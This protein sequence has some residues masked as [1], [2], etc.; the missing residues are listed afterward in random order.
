MNNTSKKVI[1]MILDGW[2]IADVKESSAICKANTSFIDSLYKNYPNSQLGTSG[3]QVGL[4]DGQMGNSEVGHMNLGAGRI[5]YQDLVKINLAVED[6]S[7][8]NEKVLVEAFEY[9]KANNKKVHFTG[10][11]SNGGVHSHIDHLK[12][13]ITAT[14]NAGLKDVFVHAFMDGRDVDPKSGKGFVEDIENFMSDT[15]A[16]LATIIGRF[17]A[18]D[19]DKRWERVKEAY[20][21]M[22]N[23]VGDKF[24][25]GVEAITTSYS[26]DIT[27]EFVKPVVLTNNDGEARGSIEE[28]DVVFMF[29]YRTD[30]GREISQVLSQED[31]H[32]YN[33]HKLD[34]HFV[35]MTNYDES[36]KNVHV[37]YDKENVK[38]TLGEI[39]SNLD[40]KQIRIAET[41]KYAHVTFFFNG[42]REL[43]FPNEERILINSPKVTTYD[44]QPEMSAAEVADALLPE[45][46]KQEAELVVLNF[47]NSDMVGHTGIFNAAMQA[48]EA[49]DKQVERVIESALKNDYTTLILADHGNSDFMINSDGSPNTAHTTNPV[50]F[51]VVS[52]DFKGKVKDGILADVAPTILDIMGIDKP[53]LMERESLVE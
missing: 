43:P 10:L 8:N 26:N 25:S 18:M 36:F 13:L 45:L 34:L 35:T 24:S 9:A 39:I 53:E 5:V 44:L 33:M 50:P 22:V 47:A 21:V 29:N 12:G 48:V 2:G 40:K 14:Q 42:G 17:Y 3:M 31:F 4:P 16:E 19:R 30:R 1:L 41:E 20:D 51:I 23:G 11:L 6:K 15:T 32:E 52:N 28:G 46:D 38:E 37:L 49:V 27:D 7:I